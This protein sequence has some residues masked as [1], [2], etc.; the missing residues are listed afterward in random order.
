M[1]RNYIAGSRA[2]DMILD[3]STIPG[4][5]KHKIR[6]P[7]GGGRITKHP[8]NLAG[9]YGVGVCLAGTTGGQTIHLAGTCGEIRDPDTANLLFELD[10]NMLESFY[11][12]KPWQIDWIKSRPH[13]KFLLDSGTFT[14][15][16]S[17]HKTVSNLDEYVKNYTD[18]IKTHGI[19]QFFEMDV[20]AVRPLSQ[21]EKYRD[22]I[23]QSTRQ[24][25]IPVWH[26]S[27]GIKYFEDMCKDYSYVAVGGI[28]TKE[29]PKSKFEVFHKLIQIA[30]HH[31]ARIHGLGI[32]SP[33]TIKKYAFDSVD[34]SSWN[35]CAFG[36]GHVYQFK[37][38][39]IVKIPFNSSKKYD[40]H[41]VVR[42]NF[43]EWVKFS[44]YLEHQY[45]HSKKT[46]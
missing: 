16:N 39:N 40:R 7:E 3:G 23:E 28:V 8:S 14:F 38:G 26:K 17:K 18:F 4:S 29:I 6:F 2:E 43:S 37:D 20:D 36:G 19:K 35:S 1:T 21:V 9:T 15:M 45:V 34:S 11:Y 44:Q 27:R 41:K 33:S 5:S 12:I 30:H 25:S 31:G 13:R 10:W 42:H 22:Y 46:I 32:G 24:Q